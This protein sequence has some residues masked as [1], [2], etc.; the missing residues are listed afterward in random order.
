MV[1]SSMYERIFWSLNQFVIC[2]ISLFKNLLD[3][4]SFMSRAFAKKIC[5]ESVAR[6]RIGS[7]YRDDKVFK[8]FCLGCYK[9]EINFRKTVVSS[10]LAEFFIFETHQYFLECF[11]RKL[12]A[13]SISC[14]QCLYTCT[15]RTTKVISHHLIWWIFQKVFD[16]IDA[17]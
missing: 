10:R 8:F 11:A 14:R 17:N 2:L 7:I 4:S 6:I 1:R 5:T 12:V 3:T 15:I 13:N 16:Q 9:W